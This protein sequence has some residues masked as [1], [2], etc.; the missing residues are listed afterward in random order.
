MARQD[1]YG[2]QRGQLLLLGLL[3]AGCAPHEA[4]PPVAG[5]QTTTEQRL[6]DQERRLQR[7]ESRPPVQAPYGNREDIQTRIGQ[8][9]A[10]RGRLLL[11]YTDQ[12]P[13]VR[14]IDRQLLILQEQ[15]RLLEP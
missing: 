3:L 9:E 4:V 10:E 11:K 15:L 8:L 2:M 1:R 12:H 14:D 7:L 13:A 6:M 5:S